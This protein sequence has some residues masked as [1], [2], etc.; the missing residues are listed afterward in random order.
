M[1][2]TQTAE[3]RRP[4]ILENFYQVIIAE[5][6]EGASIGKIAKRMNIHP[7]LI[8]HYFKNK[9]NMTAALA[10]FLIEKYEAPEFLRFDHIKDM[11]QRFHA[12]MDTI[13]SFEWSRTIDPGVHFCFYYL[14]FRNPDIHK[15]YEYIIRRFRDYLI[16]EFEG[17]RQKGIV[18]T[19]NTRMAADLI[20]T[21]MEG[22]EFHAHFLSEGQPF[23]YFAN[24]AREVALKMLTVEA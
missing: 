11:E 15:R 2:K 8:I 7:S 16:E 18:K 22:L 20:V 5:G 4:E 1:R 3:T 14:S 10:D 12:L 24:K 19:S 23:D 13:F 9:K 17:Y 21:L 6:I